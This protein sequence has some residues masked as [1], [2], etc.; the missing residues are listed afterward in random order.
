[1]IGQKLSNLQLLD[2]KADNANKDV[3][4][5]KKDGFLKNFSNKYMP[6]FFKGDN[7]EK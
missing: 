3:S 7:K 4:H 6:S 1:M 5:V 2:E